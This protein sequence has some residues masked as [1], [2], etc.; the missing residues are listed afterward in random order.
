MSKRKQNPAV[1]VTLKELD[2]AQAGL[3]GRQP[4]GEQLRWTLEDYDEIEAAM[5][6]GWGQAHEPLPSSHVFTWE[7]EDLGKPKKSGKHPELPRTLGPRVA[8]Y[9]D[10]LKRLARSAKGK[11]NYDERKARTEFPEFSLWQAVDDSRLT[12]EKRK[13]YF[14]DVVQFGGREERFTLIGALLGVG[15]LTAYDYY[16]ARPGRKP[17][18][19]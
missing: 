17:R 13:E 8:G 3:D 19:K 16:K 10:E 12:V 18:S 5:Q 6:G 9:N 15:W 4:V 1:T 2:T 14:A 7:T 11:R